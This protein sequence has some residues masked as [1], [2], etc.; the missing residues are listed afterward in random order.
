MVANQP[1]EKQRIPHEVSAPLV[2][3][4]RKDE[5]PLDPGSPHPERCPGQHSAQVVEQPSNTDADIA[6]QPRSIPM[7]P[8]FLKWVAEGHQENPGP[9]SVDGFEDTLVLRF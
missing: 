4:C 7:N 2:R 8:V 3:L 6:A 9:G 1:A 5:H